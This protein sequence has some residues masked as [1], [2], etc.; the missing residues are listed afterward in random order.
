MNITIMGRFGYN[1]I[2]QHNAIITASTVNSDAA[3]IER[4]RAGTTFFACLKG[5]QG[6]LQEAALQSIIVAKSAM[7]DIPVSAGPLFFSDG[8][9]ERSQPLPISGWH[10]PSPD[11]AHRPQRR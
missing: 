7:I 11:F 9:R 5:M 2:L 8:P 3:I 10:K 4:G 6:D 1:K